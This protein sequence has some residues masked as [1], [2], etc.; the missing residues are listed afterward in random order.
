M[1]RKSVGIISH[2]YGR[3]V[4][5]LFIKISVS[6]SNGEKKEVEALID[7][8]ATCSCIKKE[9]IRYLAPK[10]VNMI[11]EANGEEVG[12][13][14]LNIHLSDEFVI[15]NFPVSE[16]PS[17]LGEEFLIGMDIITQGDFLV[18]NY[19][20]QTAITFRIPSEQKTC[21]S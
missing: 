3:I 13:Y 5:D 19:E 15:E 11:R 1:D 7:T 10:R 9:Y 4:Y 8:G 21:F 12:T 17:Y 18:T 14:Y 20:N 16:M 6:A 2:S